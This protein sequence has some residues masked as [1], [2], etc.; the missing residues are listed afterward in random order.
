MRYE[1]PLYSKRAPAAKRSKKALKAL[2]RL[3]E[4]SPVIQAMI[5]KRA[6]AMAKQSSKVK[7]DPLPEYRPG[8][9]KEFYNTR[10]WRE[11][12]YKV[13]VKLGRKCQCCGATEGYIHVDHILPRSINPELEI[14]ESNLQVLCESCNIGKSNKDTTKF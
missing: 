12:R 5:S 2:E 3:A 6:K 11:L 8:M 10:V 13:L 9:G 1:K 14:E 7:F 4:D